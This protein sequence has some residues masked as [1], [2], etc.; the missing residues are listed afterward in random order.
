MNDY[1]N[2][3]N[4]MKCFNLNRLLND[5]PNDDDDNDDNFFKLCVKKTEMGKLFY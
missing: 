3:K 2:N 5:F 4:K 1:N